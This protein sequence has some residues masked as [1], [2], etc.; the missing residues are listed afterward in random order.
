MSEP[1]WSRR[2][3]GQGHRMTKSRRAICEVLQESEGHLT[4][5]ELYRRASAR[6]SSCGMTTIYRTLEL[7]TD[8]RLV[9]RFAFGEGQSRFELAEQYSGKPHHHHLVCRKCHKIVDYSDFLPEEIALVKRSEERL[10]RRFD[11]LIQEHEIT[12]RG[13]CAECREEGR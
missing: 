7:M 13:I 2:L 9:T 6:C 3:R 5:K 1:E 11:M 8:M 10:A 12:F 4:A